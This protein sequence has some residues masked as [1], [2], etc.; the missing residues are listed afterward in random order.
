MN[1]FSALKSGW[2]VALRRKRAIALYWVFHTLL[3]LTVA[4]P[5]AGLGISLV[6]KTKY[7]DD[8]L[9]DFDLMFLFE[10]F[11]SASRA[12]WALFLLIPL[13]ML[14]FVI[15]IYLAGGAFHILRRT[16]D[17]YS[18]AL[19]WEGAGLHFWR[20]LRIGIYSFLAW[21]P[22][23]IAG[24]GMNAASKKLWGEGMTGRPVYIASHVRAILLLLCAGYAITVVD[25]ARARIAAEGSRH[26]F[27]A[28]L[29]A[30]RFVASRPFLA[31]G[32]WAVLGSV[33]ALVTWLY[34]KFANILPTGLTP[35]VILL[36]IV[37][38]AYV[39]VRVLLRFTGWGAVIAID[40]AA[41][42]DHHEPEQ[43]VFSH[44]G[45]G[46]N[47]SLRAGAEADPEAESPQAG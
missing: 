24:P 45:G 6:A 30:I 19:F 35:L 12:E 4:I 23:A 3:A 17:A 29:R 42:G 41:R 13:F 36:I 32:P 38:Q 28:V 20:F 7:G 22:F 18:P 37:Q 10:A 1:A 14:L 5:L 46:G 25:F 16:E 44:V 31:M 21:L 26:V 47:G 9:R 8:L 2:R 43:E 27:K 39:L 34:L 40:A 33:L 11:Q 15:A